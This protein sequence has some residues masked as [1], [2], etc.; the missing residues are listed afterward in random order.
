MANITLDELVAQARAIYGNE[1][2]ALALYGSAARGDHVAK[3]SDLNVLMVVERITM[4]H[5]RREAPVARAWREAG[6]PPPLTMTR[7]E[8]LGSAD[9][10]P[11]EYA[12]ILAHHKT[13]AGTLP[14][15]G[16]QVDPKDLRLQLEHEAMSK[17]LRLRHA[18]L[19]AGKDTR[20][21]RE[22]LEQSVSTMLVLFRAMLRLV[23]DTP[24]SDSEAVCPRVQER[25]AI[26][27]TAVLRVVRHTRQKEPIALG[28][29]EPLVERYLN[30]A[31]A[32]VSYLDR[33]KH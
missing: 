12:D 13:L 24:P 27:T 14:V 20:A 17:L 22:L 26:D 32:V 31:Q 33:Y 11:M 15:E 28:E 3:H 21:L 9:V 4:E 2:V 8:W 1:L 18:V 5:L 30:A 16:I 23:G 29:A 7:V 6:N 19:L 25:C 10:F